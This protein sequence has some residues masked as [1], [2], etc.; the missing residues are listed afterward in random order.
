MNQRKNL[1]DCVRLEEATNKEIHLRER[2]GGEKDRVWNPRSVRIGNSGLGK[3]EAA[4]AI[5]PFCNLR[6][7]PGFLHTNWVHAFKLLS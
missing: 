1:R 4:H 2:R 6:C 7:I 5:E 3:A